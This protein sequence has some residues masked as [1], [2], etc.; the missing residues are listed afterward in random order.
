MKKYLQ[1]LYQSFGHIR[2]YHDVI[3]QWKGSGY[4][5]GLVLA[6]LTTV[7]VI[8][9]YFIMLQS[10]SQAEMNHI[11]DQWPTIT[12]SQ[13]QISPPADEPTTISTISGRPLII[14]D[15]SAS[16]ADLG[17]HDAPIMIGKDFML[18]KDQ[19]GS[20]RT[21]DLQRFKSNTITLD[22]E[23]IESFFKT[24]RYMPLFM[25]PFLILGQWF[26]VIALMVVAAILSYVVTAYMK[27]E[28]NFDTRMRMAAIAITPPLLINMILQFFTQHTLGMWV[29][30]VLWVLHL[31]IIVIAAR[32]YQ[33]NLNMA[34]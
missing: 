20:V 25:T 13:G 11:L 16:A 14:I 9:S 7:G 5:Y 21:T 1:A 29:I 31:Y 30:L 18:S 32:K 6:A 10:F 19:D 33:D 12:L 3:H 8:I 17:K 22:R 23:K 26:L 15:T 2:L 4:V 24:F 34:A 28:F 27:E